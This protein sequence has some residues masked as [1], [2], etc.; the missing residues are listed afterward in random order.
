MNRTRRSPVKFAGRGAL[1]ALATSVRPTIV[2]SSPVA[3]AQPAARQAAVEDVL[4]YFLR[5]RSPNTLDAYRRDLEAFARHLGTDFRGAVGRL[6]AAAPG[7]A[8]ALALDWLNAMAESGRSTSTRARRLGTLRSFSKAARAVGA[9]TW[10]LEIEGPHVRGYRDTAGP[11]IQVLG[12]MIVSAGDGLHGL[13][14][15]VILWLLGAHGLRR[16]EVCSL[17]VRHYDHERRRLLVAGKGEDA[18]RWISLSTEACTA[19]DK[20]ISARNLVDPSLPL[21]CSLSRPHWGQP[22][23]KQGLNLIVREIGEAVGIKAWPH[24]LRHTAITA[25]LE[26]GHSHRDVQGFSRHESIQT[27]LRYDD[28]RKRAGG[29][30]GNDVAASISAAINTS[31]Q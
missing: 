4:G 7:E 16:A 12:Q 23:G 3:L 6:L 24:A 15:R 27:V 9:I 19:I 10:H 18:E 2:A 25:A 14:N 31:K 21:V 28:N 8:N 30:V 13:R 26:Q 1:R 29:E 22:L 11:T 20:W 17:R 5:G